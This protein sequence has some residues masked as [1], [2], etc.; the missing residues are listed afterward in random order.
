MQQGIFR[1]V[2]EVENSTG[3]NVRGMIRG[4]WHKRDCGETMRKKQTKKYY[5]GMPHSLHSRDVLSFV[6]EKIGIQVNFKLSTRDAVN[7]ATPPESWLI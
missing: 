7:A 3:Q 1:T 5:P 6:A 4:K 2:H